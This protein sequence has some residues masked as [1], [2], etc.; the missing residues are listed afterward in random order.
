MHDNLFFTGS[1]SHD[2]ANAGKG[3]NFSDYI[4]FLEIFDNTCSSHNAQK[5]DRLHNCCCSEQK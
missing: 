1:S 5:Y 2:Q 3:N 4:T